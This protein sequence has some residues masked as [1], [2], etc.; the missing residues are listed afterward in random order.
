MKAKKIRPGVIAACIAVLFSISC[1]KETTSVE[2]CRTCTA[3][4]DGSL[5]EQT[6][7]CSAEE[8]SSFAS[9]HPYATVMC[10]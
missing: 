4:L 5:I 9:R 8:E 7:A 3:R 6:E 2:P 1:V 10:R